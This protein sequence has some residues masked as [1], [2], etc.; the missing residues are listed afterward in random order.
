MYLS[1]FLLFLKKYVNIVG[2]LLEMANSFIIIGRH[3]SSRVTESPILVRKDITL[4]MRVQQSH[5]QK[6]A[7]HQLQDVPDW[8]VS[9]TPVLLSDDTQPTSPDLL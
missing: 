7:G 8:K 4:Q 6:L 2:I 1:F 3:P 9:L 5:A